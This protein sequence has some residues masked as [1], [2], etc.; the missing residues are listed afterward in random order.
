MINAIPENI[1][2]LHKTM[3]IFFWLSSQSFISLYLYAYETI[4]EGSVVSYALFHKPTVLG[5]PARK[6][7]EM[8]LW[9]EGH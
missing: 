7:R 2:L 5:T 6:V 9:L 4:D 8:G 3:L 1:F